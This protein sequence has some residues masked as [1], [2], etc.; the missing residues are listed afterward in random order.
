MVFIIAAPAIGFGA[1]IISGIVLSLPV[2]NT[3]RQLGIS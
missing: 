2:I 1:A 3:T